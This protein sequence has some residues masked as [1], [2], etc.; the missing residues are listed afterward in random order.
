MGIVRTAL[1]MVAFVVTSAIGGITWGVSVSVLTALA[2]GVAQFVRKRSMTSPAL[3]LLAVSLASLVALLTGDRRDYF[4]IGIWMALGGAVLMVASILVRWPLVGVVWEFLRGGGLAW[5]KDR[6]AVRRYS[7]AGLIWIGIYLSRFSV[8]LALYEAD[9]VAWL[10]ASRIV[11]GWP[12]FAAGVFATAVFLWRSE[13]RSRKQR[14]A[15]TPPRQEPTSSA[16][17]G[18]AGEV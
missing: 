8:Q 5:R 15:G 14:L 7:W 18:P 3:G 6:S 10:S 12:L 9:Q 11:M 13:N 16:V 4:S 17:T 2:L 1:P